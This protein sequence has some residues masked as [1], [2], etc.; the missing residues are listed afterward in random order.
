[1]EIG[2]YI[3]NQKFFRNFSK[4]SIVSWI[5]STMKKKAEYILSFSCGE[6]L[7]MVMNGSEY[8][9]LLKVSGKRVTR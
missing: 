8:I 6:K 9:L 7:E 1:M 2:T 5:W 4:N 3:Y